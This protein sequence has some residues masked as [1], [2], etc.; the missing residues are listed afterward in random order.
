MKTSSGGTVGLEIRIPFARERNNKKDAV[1][2][3]TMLL[4]PLYDTYAI[5]M[6]LIGMW[7]S[8]TKNPMKPMTRNPTV[9][10]LA[11]CMNSVR[12]RTAGQRTLGLAGACREIDDANNH[13]Q[14]AFFKSAMRNYYCNV[15]FLEF[16]ASITRT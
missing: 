12:K 5:R 13:K 7:M 14:L 15:D 3:T 8:L 16:S 2:I 10:A 9:V 11:T 1:T 4:Y 6:L